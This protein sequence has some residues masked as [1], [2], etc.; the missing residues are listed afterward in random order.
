MEHTYEESHSASVDYFNGNELAGK[1]AVDKYLLR[2]NNNNLL[3]LTPKDKHKRLAKEFARIEKKKYTGTEIQPLTFDEIFSYLDQYKYIIPQGSVMYGCGNDHQIISLS[4]CFL[5]EAPADSYGGILATDEQ[6]VQISKRRG[7]VGIDL[8]NIRPANSVT[9]NS[10]RTT[11]GVPTF[12]ERYSNSIREVGQGGR[13]GA[14]ML[15]LSVHHPDILLF[16][17]MKKDRT[18]V[19]GANISV[20][21]TDE[22][23]QA[24]VDGTTYEQRYPVNAAIPDVVHQVDA[25]EVWLTIIEQAHDNAEP[26]LLF[27]DNVTL[28]TPAD[29]YIRFMSKGTN[30]CSELNLSELD[31]CRL[32]LLNL[33]SYVNDPY[34]Y[35]A[36]FDYELFHKHAQIAQRLMDDI[37]DLESEKIKAILKKIKNDP[38]DDDI[39]RREMEIWTKILANNDEGRRTGTGIT[40]L[41]DAL[42][43]INI[44]YGSNR[45][46][47]ITEEIYRTLKLG[48]YR[49]SVDMAKAIGPFLDWDHQLE[50]NNP[51]LLRIKDE[52]PRL[53]ADMKEYGRRNVACLTT[54]PAGS[55]SILAKIMDYFGTTSGIE[56]AFML[57]FLRRKKGNPGDDNFRSDFVD[58]MG[59]NWQ[60]FK[61]YHAGLQAWMDVTG[62]T[63][64][65]ESPYWGACAEEINWTNRVK[66]QAAAQRHVCHSISSTINLPEDVSVEEVAKIYQTAW[67][68]GVKG[69]TVYRKNCRTGV[70]VDENV[71][72]D[73][74]KIQKTKAPERPKEMDCDVHHISV[75]GHPYFV[76]VGLLHGEPYEI[77]A[78]KN[79]FIDHKIKKGQIIK[80]LR[81]K[82][83]KAELE[84]GLIISPI[85]HT[86]TAEQEAL[87]RL[88]STCLRHG[89]DILFVVE[90]L[91]KT[92]GE[93]TTFAKSMARALK[94]YI[95]DGTQTDTPCPECDMEM[96]RESGCLTCK[97]C[98]YSKCM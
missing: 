45:S 34:T 47:E 70:L 10:S 11:T 4:N 25:R 18:K 8:D 20:K 85:S 56:P 65:K 58:D 64:P 3:E 91:E 96:V 2:D 74:N 77:F 35:K 95:P 30:P 13:R 42:A 44:K 27:W 81:P 60:E 72:T 93:M 23:M 28:Y 62:K 53:W 59:D 43:A 63:D 61:V 75:Q 22:F 9:H 87:A 15:T 41:G 38:E 54:A 5:L 26:G 33:F 7:G 83:Y 19:T 6:L 82:G 50:K 84:D 36:E 31:S 24:V 40:A 46:I 14:L 97:N 16:A 37:V 52:D 1:V 17:T 66:M 90:Q 32:L 94:K 55:V 49:A 98:G 51:F 86:C 12:A 68:S 39:K 78:G 69:I 79:G 29:C 67:E 92:K 88:A 80:T 21:L 48:C 71:K 76:L 73:Y 89:A 57:W